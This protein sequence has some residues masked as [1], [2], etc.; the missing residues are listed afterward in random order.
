LRCT[1]TIR[2]RHDDH[3][4]EVVADLFAKISKA[5]S[6]PLCRGRSGTVITI[7]P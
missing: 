4:P 7:A 5:R 1:V 2:G 3:V 6:N